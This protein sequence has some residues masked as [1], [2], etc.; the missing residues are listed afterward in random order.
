MVADFP[1]KLGAPDAQGRIQYASALPID[2]LSP[3]TYDL[4]ITV[5]DGQNSVSRSQSFIIE[6]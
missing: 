2:S 5:K 1:L 3:G 4:K 6:P